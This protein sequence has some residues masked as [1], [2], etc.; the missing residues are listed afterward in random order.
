MAPPVDPVKDLIKKTI[1]VIANIDQATKKILSESIKKSIADP[2]SYDHDYL[3]YV[4]AQVKELTD[5]LPNF[6]PEQWSYLATRLFSELIVTN[7]YQYRLQRMHLGSDLQVNELEQLYGDL[8]ESYTELVE[9]WPDNPNPEPSPEPTPEPESP[10]P[11]FPV[12][13]NKKN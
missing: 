10:G 2:N 5:A 13:R 8:Q 12:S 11:D 1:K 7:Y 4:N 3:S 6:T 9:S